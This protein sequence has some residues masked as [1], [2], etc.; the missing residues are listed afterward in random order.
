MT[1]PPNPVSMQG[2]VPTRSF[3]HLEA[4]VGVLVQVICAIS[5]RIR[6]KKALLWLAIW[7]CP[8]VGV[9]GSLYSF[10]WGSLQIRLSGM[11]NLMLFFG[12]AIQLI[13]HFR[14]TKAVVWR[15]YK[16]FF[17]FAAYAALR[18]IDA[19]S[20][21][22]AL[23]E[24]VLIA[25]PVVIA[26][27]AALAINGGLSTRWIEKQLLL[28][29]SLTLV[30]LAVQVPLGLVGY[31]EEGLATV[32]GKGTIALFGLPILA[33]ALS[34]WRYERRKGWAIFAAAVSLGMILFTVSRMASAVA[35]LVLLPLRFV[36]FNRAFL[37]HAGFAAALTVLLALALLQVPAVH[38]RFLD[39]TE[40]HVFG[41]DEAIINTSGRSTMWI[42]TIVDALNRP[43]RGFGTGSS[44]VLISNLVPGLEHPH[45][46]Y[47]RVWHDLGIVGVVLFCSAWIGRFVKHLRLWRRSDKQPRFARA[48][49]AAAL[50]A[51][52]VVLTC[53]TDNTLLYTFVQIPVFLLFA[54]ADSDWERAAGSGSSRETELPA[55]MFPKG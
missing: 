46:D 54:V 26:M 24:V 43:F 14:E 21:G 48:Q 6:S 37:R 23:R 44:E 32:L 41:E 40:T 35:V 34:R 50:A 11:L 9:L 15:H 12:A 18:V 38:Y 7:M 45:N 28:S 2:S 20:K 1:S 31:D 33:L 29:I 36:H 5:S 17:F 55:A 19:P 52:V 51:S 47:L 30:L 27:C 3:G 4:S 13:T 49:M 16:Y 8:S 22:I 39:N 10:Q 25:T 42:V 53:L